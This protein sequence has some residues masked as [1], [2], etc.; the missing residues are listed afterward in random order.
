MDDDDARFADIIRKMP[1]ARSGSLS[2]GAAAKPGHLNPAGTWNQ[3]EITC[4]RRHL[5][6]RLNTTT[7]LDVDLDSFG[8][9]GF[10][11]EDCPGLTRTRGRIGLLGGEG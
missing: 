5:S 9:K 10:D 8:G 7:V 4:Q 11:G 2:L 3:F 1:S 6:V